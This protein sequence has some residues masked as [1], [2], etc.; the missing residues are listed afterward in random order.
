[1]MDISKH[2]DARILLIDYGM[3][4]RY[5]DKKTGTHFDQIL[6]R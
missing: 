1:M 5:M 4:S 2:K 3:A 6:Q